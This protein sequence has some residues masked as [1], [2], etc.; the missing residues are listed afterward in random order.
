MFLLISNAWGCRVDLGFLASAA[1]GGGAATTGDRKIEAG[2]KKYPSFDP[3]VESYGHHGGKTYPTIEVT[4]TIRL[5]SR[6]K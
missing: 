4:S 3:A 2:G 5:K 1:A 6:H